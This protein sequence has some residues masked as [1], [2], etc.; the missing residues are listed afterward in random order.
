MALIQAVFGTKPEAY[1][2]L[3]EARVT[4]TSKNVNKLTL[5]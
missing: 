3:S 2:D 1:D 4:V 5:P